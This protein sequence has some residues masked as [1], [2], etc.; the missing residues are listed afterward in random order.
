MSVQNPRARRVLRPVVCASLALLVF[1]VVSGLRIAQAQS[2]APPS[3][4]TL[5]DRELR[6]TPSDQGE[7]VVAIHKLARRNSLRATKC[8]VRALDDPFAHIRQEAVFWMQE[9][10][11][12]PSAIRWLVKKATSTRK[13]QTVHNILRVLAR[14]GSADQTD[15]LAPLADVKNR[16]VRIELARTVRWLEP[17]STPDLLRQLARSSDARVRAAAYRAIGALDHSQ[18]QSFIRKHLSSLSPRV[19]GEAC[20]ALGRT[21]GLDAEDELR[22]RLTGDHWRVRLMALRGLRAAERGSTNSK[23]A[24]DRTFSAARERLHDESWHVRVGA[25]DVLVSLWQKRV[26]PALI[27]GFRTAEGRL[28]LDYRNALQSMTGQR[29]GR[30][31]VNWA[32]WW[33]QNKS[34][35][36][37]GAKPEHWRSGL[38]TDSAPENT[39]AFFSIPLHSN[40]LTFV[41]DFSG[42]MD[43]TIEEGEFSGRTKIGLAKQELL[44]TIKNLRSEQR[45]NVLVYRYPSTFPP[46]PS[47]QS[48][49][50]KG[51]KLFP[52]TRKARAAAFR[53]VRNLQAKGWGA[54]YE[55]FRA[56]TVN[57][58]VNTIIFLSDGKPTRGKY[59]GTSAV[60][61]RRFFQALEQMNR[62][63]QVMIH[64]VLTGSGA[65]GTDADF[66][67]KIANRTGGVFVEK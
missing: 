28:K 4:E 34:S 15:R 26:I 53:W 29:R 24:M 67:K 60:A 16:T 33:Q 42:G 12:D 10:L 44:N 47:I 64:T 1:V 20:L 14:T 66:M 36:E 56:A 48:P 18:D 35:F 65:G 23:G 62:Y 31:P 39:S 2:D 25:I 43:G 19:R 37:L 55:A 8:L 13:P 61:E 45:F 58:D 54:F 7:R 46:D 17:S 63:R 40:R 22:A 21:G 59:A 51:R 3:C 27:E 9:K 30:Q 52:A 41:M 32:G 6:R 38:E 49:Y 11:T 50:K 5:H 57:P